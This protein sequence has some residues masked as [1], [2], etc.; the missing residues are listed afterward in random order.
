VATA[1]FELKKDSVTQAYAEDIWRS[2]TLHVFPSKAFVRWCRSEDGP[3]YNDARQI[4]RRT[5]Q[6]YATYLHRVAGFGQ[7]MAVT[8]D[9][10]KV[11][12]RVGYSSLMVTVRAT[13]P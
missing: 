12:D 11:G 7:H 10:F 5:L 13:P 1:W 3:G 6:T 9:G 8:D 2:L 4:D